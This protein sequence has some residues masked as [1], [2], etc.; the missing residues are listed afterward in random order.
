MRC[1]GATVPGVANEEISR[2]SSPGGPPPLPKLPIWDVVGLAYSDYYKNF[3]DVLRVSWLWLL[4]GAV[5]I[6]VVSWLQWSLMGE[7]ILNSVHHA[8]FPPDFAA[9]SFRTMALS[10]GVAD[11]VLIVAFVSI[12]VAWHRR[13]ILG[14]RPSLFSFNIATTNFWRYVGIGLA[15]CVLAI[16]PILLAFIPIVVILS[17]AGKGPHPGVAAIAMVLLLATYV[18][19]IAIALRLSMLLPARAAGDIEL[20]FARSW[21]RTRGNCW[22]IFWG[23]L[24][25]TAAP[26]IVAEMVLLPMGMPNPATL[27]AAGPDAVPA[28]FA[29]TD[30]AVHMTAISAFLTAFYLLTL[31][32]GIGFLSLAYRYFFADTISRTP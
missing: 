6:G 23:G 11:V 14:E 22:R 15:I 31:P 1:V 18:T 26:L 16:M 24:I 5:V 7:V 3:A 2:M 9:T 8:Q 28:F 13:I 12:A 29:S 21:R 17:A 4:L 19:A 27:V 30:F 20:S 25:C 10:I 32:I